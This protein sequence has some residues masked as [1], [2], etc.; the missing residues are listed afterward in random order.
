MLSCKC[1]PFV[2]KA[3]KMQFLDM[4]SPIATT[5]CFT[6]YSKL[7]VSHICEV[8]TVY[9]VCSI[10]LFTLLT[11]G[12]FISCFIL[13][14]LHFVLVMILTLVTFCEF[15]LK[16]C[17]FQVNVIICKFFSL[18]NVDWTSLTHDK[19]KTCFKFLQLYKA[20]E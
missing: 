4:V 10:G 17:K 18:K 8:C 5:W 12:Y 6:A 15:T 9:K 7:G 11:L 19:H 16:I 20:H 1:K 14:I 2:T 13:F 3:L